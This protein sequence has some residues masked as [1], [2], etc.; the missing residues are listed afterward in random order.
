MKC[1]LRRESCRRY[2]E[3]VPVDQLQPEEVY[4]IVSF[5]DEEMRVPEL[6]PVVFFGRNLESEEPGKIYF[7]DYQSF[8][9]GVR[10]DSGGE[11]EFQSFFPDQSSGVCEY[12]KA[13]EVLMR[14]SLRRRS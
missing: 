4:F 3:H 6:R 2:V 5:L 10:Y 8:A 14:C 7:Q 12:E 13:F 9:A 11:A 1:F